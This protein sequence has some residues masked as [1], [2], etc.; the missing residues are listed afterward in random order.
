MKLRLSGPA[1]NVVLGEVLQPAGLHH[2]GNG[3]CNDDKENGKVT[4]GEVDSEHVK[5]ED[6]IRSKED[7]N[8]KTTSESSIEAVKEQ[9]NK[10]VGIKD[11]T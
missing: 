8:K 7:K 2:S 6:S 4:F 10:D 5:G 9:D 3:D 1:T 11:V